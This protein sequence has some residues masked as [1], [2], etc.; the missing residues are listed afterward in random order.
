MAS[1]KQELRDKIGLRQKPEESDEDFKQRS[2]TKLNS[3]PDEKW[4]DLS[5]EAQELCNNLIKEAM[6]EK[7][8]AVEKKKEATKAEKKP[9]P[10]TEKKP[11]PVT[12]KKPK[13][14]IGA[15]A[16]IKALLCSDINMTTEVII[17]HLNKQ[18]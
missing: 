12:E 13:R 1:I 3:L 4:A 17:E 6:A 9:K 18:G 16:V 15:R 10:V 14:V 2:I 7:K 11:K 8:E 5:P